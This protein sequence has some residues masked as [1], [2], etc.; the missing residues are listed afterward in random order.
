[1]LIVTAVVAFALGFTADWAWQR[2]VCKK[3]F[4]SRRDDDSDYY[5]F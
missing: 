1:M 3:C 2:Y 4:L 5:G